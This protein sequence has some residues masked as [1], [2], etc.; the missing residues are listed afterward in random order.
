MEDALRWLGIASSIDLDDLSALG[1]GGVHLAAMGSVWQALVYGFAGVRPRGD[2][3]AV[4][5]RLPTSWAM[6]EFRLE[7]RGVRLLIRVEPDL[8]VVHA[9]RATFLLVDGDRIPC[10][11]GETRLPRVNRKDKA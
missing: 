8:I 3:L 6:F 5:P 11:A 1:A 2:M 4:D 9:A 10:A 7:F